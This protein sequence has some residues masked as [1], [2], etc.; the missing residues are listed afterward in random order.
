MKLCGVT[1]MLLGLGATSEGSRRNSLDES[2]KTTSGAAITMKA[3][4]TPVEKR[5][6]RLIGRRR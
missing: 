1:A 5:R 4:T 3:E 2:R 6:E